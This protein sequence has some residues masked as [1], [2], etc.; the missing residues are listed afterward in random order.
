MDIFLR[1]FV[2]LYF[3]YKVIL[4][5]IFSYPNGIDLKPRVG[6]AGEPDGMEGGQEK[7]EEPKGRKGKEK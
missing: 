2:F 3:I 1:T 6:L 4:R 5:I 7:G